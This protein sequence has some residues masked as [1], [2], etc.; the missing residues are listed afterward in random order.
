MADF[1]IAKPQSG[2][3]ETPGRAPP[4]PLSQKVGG[5]IMY[6]KRRIPPFPLSPNVS[7]K[8]F[9]QISALVTDRGESIAMHPV[10]RW[11]N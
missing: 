8:H 6:L 2:H 5:G 1:L 11:V 10:A 4:D 3:R 9:I 7:K